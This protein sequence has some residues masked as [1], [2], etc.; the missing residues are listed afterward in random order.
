MFQQARHIQKMRSSFLGEPKSNAD[1]DTRQGQG[2][3]RLRSLNRCKRGVLHLCK[4][5][6]KLA[7][8]SKDKTMKLTFICNIIKILTIY[9]H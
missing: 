2:Q 3:G 5:A 4:T 6:S 8:F 7:E 1:A 9:K